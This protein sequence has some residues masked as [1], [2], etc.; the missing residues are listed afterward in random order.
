MSDGDPIRIFE[1]V[2]L[3]SIFELSEILLISGRLSEIVT[4][5]W[6]GGGDV[7]VDFPF[8]KDVS[9]VEPPVSH[10]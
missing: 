2:L 9:N 10:Y 4:F 5:L 1:P 8:S 6:K 7:K 3:L